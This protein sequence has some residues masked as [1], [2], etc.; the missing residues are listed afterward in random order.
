MDDRLAGFA[1][2]VGERPDVFADPGTCCD[3][4]RSAARRSRWERTIGYSGWRQCPAAWFQLRVWIRPGRRPA[5][6]I[7][8]KRTT[9][10]PLSSTLPPPFT[11]VPEEVPF[12]QSAR[13]P[14]DTVIVVRLPLDID[15]PDADRILDPTERDR[16]RRFVFE[17]DRRRY[18]AAHGLVRLALA[19]FV[20]AAPE[21]LRFTATTY[22]KPRLIDPPF[23]L[24]FSLSHAGDGALLAITAGRE[25][26]VDLECERPVEAL[27]LA[28][29]HFAPAECA[30]L[31]A[32]DG[33]DRLRAFYRVWTRKEAFVKGVGLGLSLPLDEFE[34]SASGS[35][36]QAL[37]SCR[38]PADGLAR[39]RIA[40]LT[41]PPGWAAAVA[42]EGGIVRIVRWGPP[43]D[44]AV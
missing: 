32:V 44:G 4:R 16:A 40:P 20:E 6:P 22:G 11:S 30:A 1:P 19:R 8:L 2:G 33:P 5:A 26:G 7:S 24:R 27:E 15:V 29:H 10:T 18:V 14:P 41:M 13:L 23:D 25:V 37:L 21:A 36:E 39:W 35:V 34:V 38:T 9:P 12:P 43:V 42:V 28:R 17:R 3:C 31:A